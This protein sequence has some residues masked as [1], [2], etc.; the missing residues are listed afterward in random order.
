MPKKS[1]EFD[2]L[3]INEFELLFLGTASGIPVPDRNSSSIW[4]KVGKK[5]Y[6]LDAG[7]G[8]SQSVLKHKLP[9]NELEAIFITHCHP[10]HCTG[11]PLLLQLMQVNKREK[12]LT[13]FLPEEGI[14]PT[15]RY[16]WGC[17]LFPEFTT[18]QYKLE[19][20][21]ENH[22]YED[23][24]IQIISHLNSHL[25]NYRELVQLYSYPNRM[26]CYSLMIEIGERKIVYSSDLG[27]IYDLSGIAQEADILIVEGLHIE[28]EEL[29][30]RLTEWRVKKAIMT[31]F[32]P[33]LDNKEQSIIAMAKKYGVKNFKL[34][35]DGMKVK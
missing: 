19:K 33:G 8:V 31:H 27:S 20:L 15:A 23:K 24:E 26:Q 1:N 34:A 32:R 10:D 7:E 12:P 16:L 6:L 30:S 22:G 25:R 13:V 28:S 21:N 5:N 18:F 4:L 14:E 29:F 11:L 35:F 9:F 2:K 3:T 17:Y